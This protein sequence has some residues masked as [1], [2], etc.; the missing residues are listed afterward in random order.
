MGKKDALIAARRTAKPFAR[1]LKLQQATVNAGSSIQTERA[2]SA[3]AKSPRQYHW[4]G[5][6]RGK[7]RGNSHGNVVFDAIRASLTV[8]QGR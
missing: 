2:E 8:S 3:T 4:A 1:N 7:L 6:E 5:S